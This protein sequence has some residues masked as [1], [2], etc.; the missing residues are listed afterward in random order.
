MVIEFPANARIPALRQLWKLAFGDEE[1][2]LDKFFSTAYSPERCRCVTEGETVTAALYWF[3]T[4]CGGRKFAYLYA[5]AT[6]PEYRNQGLCRQ[7]MGDTYAILAAQGYDGVLL[8]PQEAA[9]RKMYASMGYRDCTAVTEVSCAAAGEP[10]ALRPVS[11]AEYA[12]LRRQ[13]LPAGG[14]IQEGANIA[15]LERTAALYAGE[16]FLLADGMELLGNT[17]KAPSILTALGRAEGTFRTPDG[18][19]PFAMFLPLKDN[20]PAPAYFGLAFD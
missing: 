14:V 10:A 11:G 18:D 12:R 16:D 7:L 1:A 2:F 13:Y 20:V 5:V 8:V 19:V 3:D 9:L 4:E 17:A 6:H 15:F